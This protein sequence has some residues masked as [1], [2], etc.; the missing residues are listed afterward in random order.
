MSLGFKRCE[1][2]HCAYVCN[3][4]NGSFIILLLYVDNMIVVGTSKEGIAYLKARLAR[5]F[6]MKDLGAANR[7]LRMTVLR[8]R[9]NRKIW[10]T[11]K[12]YV[13]KALRHFNM[14]NAKPV[15]TALLIGCKLSFEHSPST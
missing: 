15:N 7:I 3:H 10:I 12:S 1:A 4:G 11:Q 5:E 6:D 13:E 2:D 8:D 9:E 14:Q